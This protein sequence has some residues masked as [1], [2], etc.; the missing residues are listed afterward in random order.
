MS[1]ALFAC[2]KSF[3]T[4]CLISI[5]VFTYIP[6]QR[7]PVDLRRWFVAGSLR[8]DPVDPP[9]YAGN[10]NAK[11]VCHLRDCKSLLL[12]NGQNFTAKI[13]G[14]CHDQHLNISY[15]CNQSI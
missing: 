5:G 12:S 10:A 8:F 7:N 3:C 13:E 4:F 2:P 14:I 15:E 9:H 11:A 6:R 1:D